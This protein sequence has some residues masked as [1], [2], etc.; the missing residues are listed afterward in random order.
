MKSDKKPASRIPGLFSLFL[1][2]FPVYLMA[3]Y[4]ASNLWKPVIAQ[5]LR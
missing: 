3:V 5:L 4:S 2:L 1:T